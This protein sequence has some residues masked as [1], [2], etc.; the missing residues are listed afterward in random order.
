ME[1][2]T[3][4]QIAAA[5]GL[6]AGI[7]TSISIIIAICMKL[8]RKVV[9]EELEDIKEDIKDDIKETIEDI[10]EIKEKTKDIELDAQKNFLIQCINHI[11]H[12]LPTS[13]TMK[14]KFYETSNEYLKNGHNGYIKAKIDE[15]KRKGLI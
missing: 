12:N 6:I 7:I 5:L 2:I 10:K 3:L 1:G 8:I 13:D 11:E 4:G 14:E 15:L 9:S